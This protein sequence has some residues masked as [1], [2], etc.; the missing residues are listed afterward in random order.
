MKHPATVLIDGPNGPVRIN[1]ADFDPDLHTEHEPTKAETRKQDA[2]AVKTAVQA[3][4]PP[5]QSP[6]APVTDP[7]APKPMLVSAEGKKHFVVY[8]DGAK[9]EDNE[10]IDAKGYANE[11]AAWEAILKAGQQATD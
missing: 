1:K 9:V 5:A 10:K 11:G 2:Q 7:T 3:T 6:S 4:Q 8:A